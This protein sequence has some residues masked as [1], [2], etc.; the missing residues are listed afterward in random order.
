MK[1]LIHEEEI[2]EG[3]GRLARQLHQHYGDSPLTVVAIMTGSLVMLADLIR[4]LEMPIRISLIAVSSY[5]GKMTP[6]E[7]EIDDSRMLDIQGR[8]VLLIDDIFDTGKTLV[9]VT[10]RLTKLN[11]K[12][13]RTAVFLRKQG[14]SQVSQGPDFS[15]FDIPNKFVVGYGLDYQDLYR[16]LPYVGVL[17][18]SDLK[19]HLTH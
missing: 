19:Q 10:T 6:G 2:Q 5:R 11:P 14:T 18:E 15:V 12:S 9:E 1:V 7:I 13:I 16:N 3:I 17:E 4:R 8:D